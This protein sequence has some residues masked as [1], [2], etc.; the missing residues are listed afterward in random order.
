M[1]FHLAQ[2][3]IASFR[4]PASDP[5]N[6]D[7]IN[8]IDEVN[9]AAESHPGFIWRLLDDSDDGPDSAFNDPSLLINISVWQDVNALSDFVYRTEIHRNIMRRRA[10]WF[11][12]VETHMAL[13]WIK[14]DAQ[15]SIK[16]GKA[17]LDLLK[18]LGPSPAAFTFKNHYLPN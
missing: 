12:N 3:N 10:E 1:E 7:F 14:K 13:W 2:I 9:T 8:A 6:Q 18:E 4:S 16:D 15:P 17:K 11:V 5:V